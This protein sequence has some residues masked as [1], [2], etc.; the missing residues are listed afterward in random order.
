MCILCLYCPPHRL[1][2]SKEEET[3]FPLPPS[4]GGNLIIYVKIGKMLVVLWLLLGTLPVQ[5]AAFTC[6]NA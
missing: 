3:T 2:L 4:P 1:S 5:L 6:S